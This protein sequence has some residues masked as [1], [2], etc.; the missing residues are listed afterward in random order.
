MARVVAGHDAVLDREVAVKLLPASAVDASARE[1]FRREAR[2]TAAFSHPNVVAVYDAGEDDGQLYLVMELVTGRSLAEQLAAAGAV[3]VAEAM[4]VTEAVLAALT[5][6]HGIGIVHRDV[7]PGNVLLGDDG[8][9]KL[10]DFGI[11]RRLDEMAGD[12]T[13]DGT[14]IGTARYS[15]PEVLAGRPATAASDVYSVGVVLYEMLAGRP[16][17]DGA[18]PMAIA[19]T[20][21]AT[22]VPDIRAVRPDVPAPIAHG[23][24]R[25]TERDPARRFPSAAAM[26]AALADRTEVYPTHPAAGRPGPGDGPGH[27]RMVG[28]WWWWALTVV[29]VVVGVALIVVA[30]RPHDAPTGGAAPA[31]TS[32][33]AAAVVPAATASPTVLATTIPPVTPAPVP[34]RPTPPTPSTP[35]SP[36]SVADLQALLA[37]HPDLWGRRTADV[38]RAVEK[39]DGPGNDSAKRAQ[40]LLD[41]ANGWVERGEL[42][43]AALPVLRDVLGPLDADGGE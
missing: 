33:A 8:T 31:T 21:H 22:A 42:D 9:V 7:K 35:R 40:R 3:S 24:A 5:A 36:S 20:Q 6:A 10:A 4:R 26:A 1:R 28:S 32:P 12:L 11:A 29:L 43:A 37:A 18:T 19:V 15:A 13:A 27:R 41:Q 2:S 17:Y 38:R 34:T 39:L 14:F 30:R 23:I 25:A 16:A